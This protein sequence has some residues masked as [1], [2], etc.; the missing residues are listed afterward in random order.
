MKAA[1]NSEKLGTFDGD[2][3][4]EERRRIQRMADFVITNPDMLHAGILPNHNR[5]WKSFLN[6]LRFIV[7]DEV[8]SYRG[9]FGSHLANV[10]RRLDRLC[11]FYGSRPQFL[12]SSATIR[13]PLELVETL[14]GLP[15]T[16][17]DDDG[18]PRVM[19]WLPTEPGWFNYSWGY[20]FG[21]QLYDID[22]NQVT[23]DSPAN[24]RAGG[25]EASVGMGLLDCIGSG[26]CS[27][28]Y[29]SHIPLVQYFN[30]A[31]GEM[32]SRG[33]AKQKQ[34]ETKRLT[35]QRTRR[36]EAIKRAKR[37]AM[38]KRKREQQQPKHPTAATK[39]ATTEAST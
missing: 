25:L 16:L 37:E 27:Y 2:T 6:R 34:A 1:M 19:G 24:I 18:S 35:E 38:L 30:Y 11:R 36:M 5:S 22:K 26:S 8:H 13:N 17:I 39:P 3:P 31:K 4:L 14:T 23:P 33:R 29:P 20:Y 12:C 10:L 21:G 32:T 7:V 28:V 9:I 15:F